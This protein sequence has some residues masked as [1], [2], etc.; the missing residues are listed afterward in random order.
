MARNVPNFRTA[1]DEERWVWDRLNESI[2]AEKEGRR[3]D[4]DFTLEELRGMARNAEEAAALEE[5]AQKQTNFFRRWL[6]I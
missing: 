2:R 4:H 1:S 5:F 3:A 6:G